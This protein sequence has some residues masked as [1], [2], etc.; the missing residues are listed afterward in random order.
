M[1][2]VDESFEVAAPPEVV[3]PIVADP[4]A[5]VGCV[6]GAQIV[7]ENPDGSFEA[8]LGVKFGPMN[9]AFQAHAELTLDEAAMQG[10]ISARGK[11]KLGG[12]RFEAVA[13]FGVEPTA[14]GSLVTTRGEVDIS[15]RLASLIEGGANVVVKRMSS[16]FATCL[17]ARC[18]Q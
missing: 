4:Y 12:A 14:D 15:G 6:P 1:I 10:Q 13:S 9:V 16:D 5:V 7:S 17:R 8:S 11:D 3:W 2:E 18:S